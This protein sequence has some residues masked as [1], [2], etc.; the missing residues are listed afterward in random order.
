LSMMMIR[1][2]GVLAQLWETNDFGVKPIH[3]HN[4]ILFS[5]PNSTSKTVHFRALLT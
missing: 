2:D 3:P 1:S 4:E 5:D